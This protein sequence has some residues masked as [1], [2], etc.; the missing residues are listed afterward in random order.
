MYLNHS[1]I[2]WESLGSRNQAS[3]CFDLGDV[4]SESCAVA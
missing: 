3:K 1:E 4:D 2:V